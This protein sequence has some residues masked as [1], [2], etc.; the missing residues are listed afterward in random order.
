MNDRNYKTI[1]LQTIGCRLNQYETEKIAAELCPYGF[2]RVG[3]NEPADLTVI[4][5]CTV[6]HRADSDCRY[7]IRR[8]HRSNPDGKIVVVGC[9]VEHEPE[10][11]AAIEGVNVLINNSEKADI[12]RILQRKLP[13]LF[14]GEPDKN[15]EANVGQFYNRNRAW[16]KI[17]DGCNQQCSYCLV[18]IVRGML[19]NRSAGEIVDEINMLVEQGYREIV[20]TGVNIG[21]YRDRRRKPNIKNLAGLCDLII[22]ETDLYRIRLSSI[23]PQVVTDDLLNLLANS[24][25][26]I[27]RHFH[28]PLQSASDRILRLMR[29]PYNEAKFLERVKAIRQASPGTLIGADVIVGF[30]D[31]SED[32]FEHTRNLCESGVVDYLHV[33]S[34]SDRPGTAA[35]EMPHKVKPEII[36]DRSKTLNKIS[37]R[38]LTKARQRHVGEILEV[39]SEKKSDTD[40]SHFAVADNY[41]R[42]KLPSEVKTGREIVRVKT[43]SSEADYL[44]CDVIA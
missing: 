10:R 1:R 21:Y 14:T 2:K 30:P 24:G 41:L 28:L 12:V 7:L 23:E 27:C 13:E 39:I 25:G 19:V 36:H 6:T 34:Y 20:L 17:S 37:G 44:K 9:Y 35:A 15:C 32:D 5:T 38:I 29:R 8:A 40:G 42:V 4:N 31:E 11:L 3:K 22:R 43:L 16:L 33:F 18:T 26:R